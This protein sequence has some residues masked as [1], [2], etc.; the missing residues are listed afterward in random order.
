MSFPPG[1]NTANFGLCAVW[2]G[3]TGIYTTVGSNGG[4]SSCG[5]LDQSG[6]V[7]EWN[8]LIG[9]GDSS[10]G[11]RGGSW[12][13]NASNMSSVFRLTNLPTLEFSTIG[14]RVSSPL[15]PL[16]LSH[17]V[18]VGDINN[19]NDS[20]G[21]GSVN[22]NYQIGKYVVTNCEYVDFLNSVAAIDL[23]S[24]YNINMSNDV[25]GGILRSGNPGSYTYAVKSN[26]HNKPVV[27]V[28]WFDASR[29]C[30]WLHNGKPVGNQD[31][32]TTE[33][34]AY[35]LNGA[36]T[37]NAAGRNS[38]AN[39]YI[40]TEDE[41]YKAAYYKGGGTNA[42]YWLY[43]TQSNTNPICVT[44]N[45]V[46]DGPVASDYVCLSEQITPTPT[47]TTTPTTT[48]GLAL[49][50]DAS[51]SSSI[52]FN[53][54]SVVEWRDLSG[55]GRHFLQNNPVNQPDST[56]TQNGLRVIDFDGTQSM[57]G[58]EASLN[59]ARNVSELTII[60]VQKTDSTL[61]SVNGGI[62]I[63]ISTNWNPNNSRAG[64][65]SI[66]SNF[67]L[68]GQKSFEALGR[69]PDITTGAGTHFPFNTSANVI[70]GVFDYNNAQVKIYEN[71]KLKN[72]NSSFHTPGLT[73]DSDSASIRIGISDN[74]SLAFDGFIAEMLIYNRLLSDSERIQIENYLINKWNIQESP[75]FKIN[76]KNF[77]WIPTEDEWYK[78]A[79]YDPSLNN[80]IGG[81]WNY[82]TRSNDDPTPIT[83]DSTGNGS[84]GDSGN[85]ANYSG[86]ANWNGTSL[87]NVTS[88]G[89][90]GD[91]SYYGTFD[92]SGNIHEWNDAITMN[93]I[94]RGRRGGDW[95]DDNALTG[96]SATQGR[97]LINNEPFRVS[98]D[99]GFRICSSIYY[100]NNNF[101]MVDNINNVADI[102][103]FGAVNYKYKIGKYEVTNDEYVEF[104]NSI[105]KNDIYNTYNSLMTSNIRGG[106]I[107]N[108]TVGN[109]S[110]IVKPNMGNKPVN[111]VS[112]FS[113]ARYCNWLTNGK[114]VGSQN[115]YTTEN[116]IYSLNGANTTE[117]IIKNNLSSFRINTKPD[118]NGSPVIVA[119]SNFSNST[120]GWT[121]EPSGSV[122]LTPQDNLLIAVDNTGDWNWIKAPPSFINAKP[123]Y[124]SSI[125]F[126]LRR[127]PPT[128]NAEPFFPVRVALVGN[129]V[130]IIANGD[131]P[132]TNFDEYVIP[133]VAG[134]FRVVSL[135]SNP[136]TTLAPIATEQQI[137][138]V[139]NSL[140]DLYLSVEFTNGF[141]AN[142]SS[143]WD[144]I[145]LFNKLTFRIH[146]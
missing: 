146:T 63:R 80:G 100:N 52:T 19:S 4:P 77:F 22:Y 50:L 140:T 136:L 54:N 91:P 119:E 115:K 11:I 8:D 45:S 59:L 76:K 143:E 69:R 78:A 10:R 127:I 48:P 47:P 90:N 118:T 14:F 46:G 135:Q 29:Y 126:R 123:K 5:T 38:I 141:G 18:N 7:W 85:F 102:T 120:D 9:A 98:G 31:S 42:G 39:Y 88:V 144:Y 83:A 58:N 65:F 27:F 35:T 72:T 101:V 111:Y 6:N 122:I 68:S 137:N 36:T 53:G 128:I 75:K 133:F 43:A 112:W 61:D 21:Y 74:G 24:L 105:A 20:N 103:S 32:S 17:F 96:L 124:G 56:R 82:A 51:E 71:G 62:I 28:S 13:T 57:Q 23:Y 87:G 49:W 84:S 3:A 117:I 108:G 145:R 73:D 81:Y 12:N 110:Y 104:L 67:A 16:N 138:S 2:N 114:P 131:F 99:L 109:Y 107:R 34:G 15:N 86:T 142:D 26:M 44:A 25:R 95:E 64:L 116:G 139:L 121:A 55:N 92:M 94:G 30:N 66:N 106:I 125:R 89:T 33:D 37:G 97:R 113:C 60:V 132:T 1:N 130:T 70:G 129:S 134:S 41:W 93:G 40:P 79:Y